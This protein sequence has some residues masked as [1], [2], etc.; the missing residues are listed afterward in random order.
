MS[1]VRLLS[2]THVRL[3]AVGVISLLALPIVGFVG[4]ANL[5]LLIVTVG[6]WAITLEARG[7][8]PFTAVLGGMLI[9]IFAVFVIGA[10]AVPVLRRIPLL[11]DLLFVTTDLPEAFSARTYVYDSLLETR[12]VTSLLLGFLPPLIAGVVLW[13]TVTAQNK[14]ASRLAKSAVRVAGP[15]AVVLVPVLLGAARKWDNPFEY[16]AG[17]MSGDGRNFFLKVQ[18]L[19]A[20]STPTPLTSLLGQGDFLPSLAAHVSSGLGATGLVDI[21][22]QYAIA[23]AYLLMSGLIA[24]S[25]GALGWRLLQSVRPEGLAS[26]GAGISSLMSMTVLASVA[27]LAVATFSPLVNEI[28]RSGFLSHFGAFAF[29]CAFLGVGF[30]TTNTG[31]N[32]AVQLVALT[33][34]VATY[35]LA[36]GVLVLPFLRNLAEFAHRRLTP[37]MRFLL[38]T[39]AASG[40]V[41]FRPWSFVVESV[42]SR[43]ALP[44]SIVPSSTYLWLP[45]LVAS[46]FLIVV[47]RRTRATRVI[48]NSM[49]IIFGGVLINELILSQREAQQLE[50]W[51]YYGEKNIYIVNFALLAIGAGLALSLIMLGIEQVMRSVTRAQVRAVGLP[52]VVLLWALVVWGAAGVVSHPQG[53]V[54]RGTDWIQPRAGS[55]EFAVSTWPATDVMYLD[56]SDPGEARML[57][58]WLPYSWRGVGWNWAYLSTPSDPVAA[59]DTLRQ[60]PARVLSFDPVLLDQVMADCGDV[61]LANR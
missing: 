29:V 4:G 38:A 40:V 12:L 25:I 30:V 2:S 46:A 17:T 18:D 57:N 55:V 32:L 51:G 37:A 27:G 14:S 43:T 44:G 50:G 41:V 1:D 5:A 59:C 23:A 53:L 6:L 22:D 21:R 8:D 36:A 24:V 52:M 31:Q 48:E 15:M 28:F 11:S 7:T 60:T 47:F 33:L 49:L 19:R 9:S 56:S 54:L 39:S 35:P 34:L 58:F 61:V 13:R 3:V 42:R 10:A 16:L 26:S 20:T 45:L